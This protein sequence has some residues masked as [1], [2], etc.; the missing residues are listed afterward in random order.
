MTH[1]LLQ[2]KGNRAAL[3]QKTLVSIFFLIIGLR[4][5]CR[6]VG[7]SMQPTLNDGDLLIYKRFNLKNH[8]LKEGTLIILRHPLK[9]R[10]LIVKRVF[11]LS[12][13]KLEV[14]GDNENESVDSRKFGLVNY[15]Q[16]KGI[17]ECVLSKNIN[18]LVS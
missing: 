7:N 6:V 17:V 14:R 13:N 12:L 3:N 11:R 16:V 15:T 4:Q 5:H 1:G 8:K 9:E 2:A 18:K 10:T